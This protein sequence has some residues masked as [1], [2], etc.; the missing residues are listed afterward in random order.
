MAHSDFQLRGSGTRLTE[1]FNTVADS[2]GVETFAKGW[3]DAARFSQNYE[4]MIL[5]II[6]FE[7]EDL[8]KNRKTPTNI[9][10]RNPVKDENAPIKGENNKQH[11]F[12]S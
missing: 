1:Y 2:L 3:P 5:E 10:K 12:Q 4:Y 8:I 6:Q 9:M 7:V 11:L